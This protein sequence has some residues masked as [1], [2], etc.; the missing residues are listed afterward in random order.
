MQR[1]GQSITSEN[2]T[3][4][5]A[6]ATRSLSSSSALGKEAVE[7]FNISYYRGK[8]VILPLRALRASATAAMGPERLAPTSNHSS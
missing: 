3:P 1:S 4:R 7:P 8:K 2:S 6:A 5:E